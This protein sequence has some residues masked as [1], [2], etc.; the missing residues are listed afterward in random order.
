MARSQEDIIKD[1]LEDTRL[2]IDRQQTIIDNDR[3]SFKEKEAAR[4]RQLVLIERE[5]SIQEKI[6][7]LEERH[8]KSATREAERAEKSAE[9][10]AQL[11]ESYVDKLQEQIRQFN[12][13]TRVLAKTNKQ[14]TESDQK[15]LD[16]ATEYQQKLKQEPERMKELIKEHKSLVNQLEDE[17]EIKKQIEE[18]DKKQAI[19]ESKRRAAQVDA[20]KSYVDDLEKNIRKTPVIGDLLANTLMGPK[21]KHKL[22]NQFYKFFK[23]P[24]F[25]KK[26]EAFSKGLSVVVSGALIAISEEE[27]WKKVQRAFATTNDQI[28]QYRDN[29]YRTSVNSELELATRENL[30]EATNELSGVYGKLA[31][32]DMKRLE[33]QVMLT[34]YL[35][36]QGEEAAEIQRLGT[37]QGKNA[38]VVTQEV[39]AQV[40]GFNKLTGAGFVFNDIMK[41]V[42]K[43]T[44][45]LKLIFKG[46]AKELASAIVTVKGLGLELSDV[47]ATADHLLDIETSVTKQVQ[48]QILTG[49]RI[50]LDKARQL[51]FNNDLVGV[52]GELVKQGITYKDL[53]EGN[54]IGNKLLAESLGMSL[55]TLSKMVLE[56]E[57]FKELG[58]D[59]SKGVLA[60]TNADRNRLEYLASMGDETAKQT[61]EQ[62]KQATVQETL[63]KAMSDIKNIIAEIAVILLPALHVLANIVGFLAKYKTLIYGIIG[64]MT[65]GPLGAIV[66]G[67]GGFVADVYDRSTS[68]QPVQTPTPGITGAGSYYKENYKETTNTNTVSVNTKET[69]DLLK[70]LINKVDQPVNVN[71]GDRAINQINN[72]IGLKRSYTPGVNRLS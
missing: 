21:A 1:R 29:I 11:A 5:L 39:A 23:N 60:L 7:S 61:I 50:N 49:K 47:E 38:E 6:A 33:D 68:M 69:N 31:L 35:G 34:K 20:T 58:V 24:A 70:Q 32:T 65:G 3:K 66:G 41:D 45:T 37:I 67:V 13:K 72:N 15:L 10:Q 42:A 64:G 4:K 28:K 22:A 44:N 59:I 46:S 40:E 8:A 57:K 9:K 17:L 30:V 14:L 52:T 51:A 16:F 53:T 63:N 25:K 56:Q 43:S 62:M 55:E 26:M 18:L 12:I 71:I 19:Y 36:L 27:W 2:E 54:R 48:A